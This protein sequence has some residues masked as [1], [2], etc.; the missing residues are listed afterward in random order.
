KRYFSDV[1]GK[2]ID[3]F[4]NQKRR[5]ELRQKIQP[6]ILRRTKN[7]VAA[8]L[9]EKVYRVLYSEMGDKQR[10][11]YDAYEKEFR[12]FICALSGDKLDNSPMHVLRGLTRLRQICNSP[13]L[14][15]DGMLNT[16]VSAK[17]EL[18]K[19]QVS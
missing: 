13:A 8:E 17:I 9:P 6:F 4:K 11:V 16:A 14:L 18:L 19:E 12:D 5:N 15:P 10:Q 3:Q 7:E 2:P 1:Y